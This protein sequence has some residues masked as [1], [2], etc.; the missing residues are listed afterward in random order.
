MPRDRGMGG[1]SKKL[2]K[3]IRGSWCSSPHPLE[4]K[5]LAKGSKKPGDYVEH[6]CYC[7]RESQEGI[8]KRS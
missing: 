8:K 7:R 5:Y 2:R 1:E 6:S 3:S 4:E